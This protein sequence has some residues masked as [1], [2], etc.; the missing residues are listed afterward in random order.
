MR[1]LSLGAENVGAIAIGQQDVTPPTWHFCISIN[2]ISGKVVSTLRKSSSTGLLIRFFAALPLFL[3]PAG[4]VSAAFLLTRLFFG[5][6]SSVVGR[7]AFFT[8]SVAC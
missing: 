5:L 8:L 7:F 4:I 2:S 1:K 6:W 3:R